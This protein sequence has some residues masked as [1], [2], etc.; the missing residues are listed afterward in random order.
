MTEARAARGD[1]RDGCD[2]SIGAVSA[3]A[4]RTGFRAGKQWR[5]RHGHY[6]LPPAGRRQLANAAQ[7]AQ[8]ERDY[9]F[10]TALADIARA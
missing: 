7:N 2:L 4:F 1:T 9:H 8:T 5:K 6:V 3:A 10:D